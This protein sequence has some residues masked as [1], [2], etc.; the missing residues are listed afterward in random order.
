MKVVKLRASLRYA[1]ARFYLCFLIISIVTVWLLTTFAAQPSPAAQPFMVA[2]KKPSSTFL[3]YPSNGKDPAAIILFASG[4]GGWDGLEDAVARTLQARNYEVIGIDSVKYAT[5]DYDLATLQSDYAKIAEAAELPYGVHAPPLIV[6]GYSMGAAQA[7]AVA[8]G[9]R[10]PTNLKGLL[11]VDPCSRGR[12]GLRIS[13]QM[14]VLPTGAGTFSMNDFSGTMGHLRVVQWHADK[15]AIDSRA[16]LVSLTAPHK[17]F[18][19]PNAGH[20]YNNDR[21]D[22]L[23]Q[24]ADS[25]GWILSQPRAVAIA[26]GGKD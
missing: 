19:F 18:D 23:G 8:G 20:D 4:D 14:N 3:Q 11:L 10:P 5:T 13:D 2:M 22:F 16:W 25:V 24:L 17:E 6:G 1:N 9:P 26:T 21:K 12:Y 15:D 7:I